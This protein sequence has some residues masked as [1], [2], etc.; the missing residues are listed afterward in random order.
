MAIEQR[1]RTIKPSIFLNDR[2]W[3]LG[4]STGL[5]VFQAF[6]GLLTT[7][8]RRGRFD[9]RPR[10]LA[11][12]IMP[13]FGGAFEDVLDALTGA[14]FVQPYSVD[15]ERYGWIPGFER[16]QVVNGRERESRRPAPPSSDT[17][18]PNGTPPTGGR[19]TRRDPMPTRDDASATRDD[20]CTTR[21]PVLNGSGN[22]D[23]SATRDD[24]WPTR[25]DAC[26]PEGKGREGKG[27][28][29]SPD[30][31]VVISA[32]SV[33]GSFAGGGVSRNDPD[34]PKPDPTDLAAEAGLW[35]RH[36]P[37]RGPDYVAALRQAW[38]PGAP[39]VPGFGLAGR[40]GAK[41][42]ECCVGLDAENRRF[43]LREIVAWRRR[44]AQGDYARQDPIRDLVDGDWSEL[45]AA[46]NARQDTAKPTAPTPVA[47]W[48]P[49]PADLAVGWRPGCG[50]PRPD[51]GNPWGDAGCSAV[52]GPTP[53]E[54]PKDAPPYRRA[55]RGPS[56]R[57]PVAAP[58]GGEAVPVGALVTG[59]SWGIDK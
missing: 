21:Q 20:A 43:L 51:P 19:I 41:I 16:H 40:L 50:R 59:G 3:D 55:H 27:K 11:A 23:A 28:G 42:F 22:I 34:E 58:R 10:P 37:S 38:G 57:L 36:D 39:A 26:M 1:I 52:A 47:D 45:V 30:P 9:W 24:A 5:P 56:V 12:V 46:A 25:F 48:T 17:A 13:W 31:D 33:P 49:T 44:R 8:D 6:V 29:S 2:L 32:R 14:G 7:A 4:Q 53:A 54:N 15:G 18:P 35:A